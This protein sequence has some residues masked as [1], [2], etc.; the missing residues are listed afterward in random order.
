MDDLKKSIQSEES[1]RAILD[2]MPIPFAILGLDG[3]KT[4]YGN[5]KYLNF[6]NEA[7][8]SCH[9][10][11]G[12]ASYFEKE[13]FF[14]SLVKEAQEKR[15]YNKVISLNVGGYTKVISAT[16]EICS[17][18]N[19]KALALAFLDITQRTK[20]VKRLTEEEDKYSS[21]VES[22]QYGVITTNEKGE[23][24]SANS[25]TSAVLGHSIEEIIGKKIDHFFTNAK[26]EELLL[27]EG[28]TRELKIKQKNGEIIPVEVSSG[29]FFYFEDPYF[30]VCIQN[31]KEKKEMEKIKLKTTR[32]AVIGETTAEVGH[33]I[34]NPLTIINAN[35]DK[36]ARLV[37][38][39]E[40]DRDKMEK[41]I[42]HQK[43]SIERIVKI[44]DGLK[45]FSRIN[46]NRND[47]IFN[48]ND[49]M[50]ET[51]DLIHQIYAKD[52]IEIELEAKADPPQVFGDIGRVQQVLMNFISN[53]RDAL[54]S[55]RSGK[56]IKLKSYNCLGRVVFSVTDNGPGIHPE[57]RKRI[58]ETFFTTKK[59][60]KGT[61]LGLSI[62]IS[63]IESMGGE[64]EVESSEGGGSTFQASLPAYKGEVSGTLRGGKQGTTPLG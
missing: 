39:E 24:K 47:E 44:V 17:L 4:I 40:L 54:E 27:A 33:E 31:I 19:N 41:A 45:N 62:S 58:F 57:V 55:K 48:V 52:N 22:L 60:G 50:Q 59:R 1:L 26:C 56:T 13:E 15:I 29:S 34:K 18:H 10:K 36:L 42:K 14:H 46:E 51:F 23:I 43:R 11:G 53:A 3:K 35:T 9:L 5:L 64:I 12:L 21:L 37:T 6:F 2:I 25:A 63:I 28:R 49:M 8:Q 16:M 32:L 30:V 61:G 38:K 7:T 20:F